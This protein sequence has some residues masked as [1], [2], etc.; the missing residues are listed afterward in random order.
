MEGL[1]T[2]DINDITIRKLVKASIEDT[3]VAFIEQSVDGSDSIGIGHLGT[4]EA[5]IMTPDMNTVN[6]ASETINKVLK[7]N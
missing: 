2:S 7:E 4:T 1:Y 3:N 5:W 6:A